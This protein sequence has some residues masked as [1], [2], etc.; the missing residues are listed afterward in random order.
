MGSALTKI[1]L[2]R[3]LDISDRQVRKLAK[4]GM[5]TNSLEAAQSWRSSRMDA[6]QAKGNRIDGNPGKKAK[7]QPEHAEQ[8]GTGT[9]EKPEHVISEENDGNG[10]FWKARTLREQSLAIREK[11]ETELY[12]GMLVKREDVER[13]VSAI[14]RQMRDGLVNSSRRMAAEL[15]VLTDAGECEKVIDREHRALLD[16]MS[17]G[18]SEKFK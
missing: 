9:S 4:L 3:L 1:E 15:A 17:R 10:D 13:A 8:S 18:F 7:Q 16:T 14:M 5:P 11:A 6:T 2:A 12:L